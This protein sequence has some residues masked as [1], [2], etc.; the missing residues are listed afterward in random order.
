MAETTETYILRVSPVRVTGLLVLAGLLASEAWLITHQLTVSVRRGSCGPEYERSCDS[1]DLWPILIGIGLIF[2]ALVTVLL[3]LVLAHGETRART[4]PWGAFALALPL[5]PLLG[6]ALALDRPG[7]WPLRTALLLVL[8]AAAATLAERPSR[9]RAVAAERAAAARVARLRDHGVDTPATVL[10]LGGGA[11]DDSGHPE[12]QLTVAFRTG[13]RDHQAVLVASFPVYD[14]PRRGDELTIRHDPADPDHLEL[15]RPP[16][17]T[18][19]ATAPPRL[20]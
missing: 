4:L 7:D 18:L 17:D 3:T 9:R 14:L 2:V 13:G 16:A 8:L 12:L 19:D 11:A 20:P 1:G 15:V 6:V 10:A 5:G